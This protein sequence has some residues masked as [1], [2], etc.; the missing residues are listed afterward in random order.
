MTGADGAQI[1][2]RGGPTG[3]VIHRRGVRSA[4]DDA[5][6]GSDSARQGLGGLV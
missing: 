5:L 4:A 2:L 6:I 1:A 3:R